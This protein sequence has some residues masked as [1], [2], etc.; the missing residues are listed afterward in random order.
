MSLFFV[1]VT[2]FSDV[3]DEIV[4]AL[5]DGD[6]H[7]HELPQNDLSICKYQNSGEVDE[8]LNDFYLDQGQGICEPSDEKV[9]DDLPVEVDAKNGLGTEGGFWLV[10]VFERALEHEVVRNIC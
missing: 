2:L 1:K 3:E 6:N 9:G 7:L 4:V 10:A 5:L 8:D